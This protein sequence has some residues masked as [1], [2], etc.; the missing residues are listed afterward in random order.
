[1]AV[2]ESNGTHDSD[3]NHNL[4]LFLHSSFLTGLWGKGTDDA[5]ADAATALGN[6]TKTKAY[7]KQVLEAGALNF[8]MRLLRHGSGRAKNNAAWALLEL[9]EYRPDVVVEAGGLI[10]ALLEVPCP[11]LGTHDPFSSSDPACR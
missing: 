2:G 4:D 8:L 5:Q 3:S 10:E 6:I 1:M 7:A 11:G 9:V